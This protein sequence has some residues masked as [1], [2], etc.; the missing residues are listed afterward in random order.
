MRR[1]TAIPKRNLAGYFVQIDKLILKL[2]YSDKEQWERVLRDKIS[3]PNFK[4]HCGATTVN[5]D[6]IDRATEFWGVGE[7]EG[8]SESTHPGADG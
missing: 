3:H 1:V 5:S 6:S 7:G 2:N 8:R 4:H